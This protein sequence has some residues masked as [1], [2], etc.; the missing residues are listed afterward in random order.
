VTFASTDAARYFFNA[1][2]QLNLVLG[3]LNATDSGSE[4][5]FNRL[6]SAMS[7]IGFRARSNTGRTG[8]GLTLNTNITAFGYYN[9]VF[10][11]ATTLVQVTDTT[12]GYTGSTG[13]IQVYTTSSDPTNGGKGLNVV[14]RTV[15]NIAD[16]IWDDTLS[17]TYRM[18]VDIVPPSTTYLNNSWGTPTVS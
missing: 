17:L 16:K 11:S 6:V 10:N 7:G 8:T 12:T 2:G 3:F 5:S 18:R 14:F 9:N 13:F 15:Y 4:N 1:G